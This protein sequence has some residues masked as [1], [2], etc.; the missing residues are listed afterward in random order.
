MH[1]LNTINRLNAEAFSKS[2][3]NFRSQGRWVLAQYEGLHL[4]SI[5]TFSTA[6]DAAIALV[7]AQEAAGPSDHFKLL[8][9]LP[10]WHGAKRDQSED[11]PTADPRTLAGYISRVQTQEA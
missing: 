2:I 7:G 6:E 11:R 1:D 5:E 9:P 4:L 3:E 8:S 10:A